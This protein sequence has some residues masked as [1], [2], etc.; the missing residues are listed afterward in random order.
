M[1]TYRRVYRDMR[2]TNGIAV[3]YGI[4]GRVEGIRGSGCTLDSAKLLLFLHNV[5]SLSLF[6]WSRLIAALDYYYYYYDYDGVSI[7]SNNNYLSDIIARGLLRKLGALIHLSH[8]FLASPRAV[9]S[10]RQKRVVMVPV[11]VLARSNITVAG[12]SFLSITFLWLIT[13]PSSK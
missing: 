5:L 10:S 2:I 12:T 4:K 7:G 1:C 8:V 3:H 6:F 13:R 9:L 11:I